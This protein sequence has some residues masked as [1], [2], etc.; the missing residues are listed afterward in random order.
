LL[1]IRV[2]SIVGDTINTD[3]FCF[4]IKNKTLAGIYGKSK[5]VFISL[6]SGQVSFD[7][8]IVLDMISLKGDYEEYL[9]QIAVITKDSEID[10]ELSVNDFLDF[11][12]AMSN[13]CGDMYEERK[14]TLLKTFG[15]H[16]FINTSITK[17]K[18]KDRR[19]IKLISLFL[20]ERTLI[21]IDTFLDS[22]RH[23]ELNK[24]IRFL[25]NYA[26]NDKIVLIGSDNYQ[27]LESFSNTIYIID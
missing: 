10:T 15:L 27:L 5:H 4:D 6:L 2:K 9:A 7:G 11:F 25:H 23:K 1:N 13:F 22:F 16:G 21:M 14:Y 18:T 20:Q 17:L 8:D 3:D 19:L 24:I 26:S 12:G